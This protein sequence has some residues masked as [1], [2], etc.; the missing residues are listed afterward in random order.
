M[1]VV[2]FGVLC[3]YS[4]GNVPGQSQGVACALSV[5]LSAVNT[6]IHEQSYWSETVQLYIGVSCIHSVCACI[7]F[8]VSVHCDITTLKSS[9][10]I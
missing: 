7:M 2:L 10:S 3:M 6:I 4:S 5:A 9:R 8:D 1:C